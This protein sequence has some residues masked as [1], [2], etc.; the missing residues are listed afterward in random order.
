V[1]ANVP[2]S[3]DSMGRRQPPEHHRRVLSRPVVGSSTP[4]RSCACPSRADGHNRGDSAGHDADDPAP[5]RRKPVHVRVPA[6]PRL[7]CCSIP[8]REPGN[9]GGAHVESPGVAARTDS[10]CRRRRRGPKARQ[11]RGQA[12]QSIARSASALPPTAAGAAWSRAGGQG[13]MGSPWE[14]VRRRGAGHSPL[15]AGHRAPPAPPL[16]GRA[17][18]PV[19]R[20][21]TSHGGNCQTRTWRGRAGPSWR[22]PVA[23]VGGSRMGPGVTGRCGA[24]PTR[25]RGQPVRPRR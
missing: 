17:G 7:G 2:Q 21:E 9:I 25:S 12:D 15:T 1:C 5:D 22:P 4:R 11:E 16:P 23:R 10:D 13:R 24:A 3:S 20:G 19:R 18:W 8:G 6:I 14:P